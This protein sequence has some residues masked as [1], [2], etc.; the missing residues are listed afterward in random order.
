MVI[1]RPPPSIVIYKAMA[2]DKR[3]KRLLAFEVTIMGAVVHD[4]FAVSLASWLLIRT[5][6]LSPT[7]DAFFCDEIILSSNQQHRG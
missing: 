5:K 7:C 4:F 3:C 6:D 2:F 1:A